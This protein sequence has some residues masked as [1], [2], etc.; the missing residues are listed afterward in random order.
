MRHPVRRLQGEHADVVVIGSMRERRAEL[1]VRFPY[2]WRCGRERH[3]EP[4][5]RYV[6]WEGKTDTRDQRPLHMPRR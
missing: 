4:G 6:T 2:F 1:G 5:G 3:R